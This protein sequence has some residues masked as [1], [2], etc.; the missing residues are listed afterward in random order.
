MKAFL[1]YE[2]HCETGL[3]PK[4]ALHGCYGIVLRGQADFQFFF[5]LHIHYTQP[6][7][8][9]ERSAYP[10]TKHNGNFLIEATRVT[11]QSY[12]SRKK[13]SCFREPGT[14]EEIAVL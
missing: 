11:H 2:R 14:V 5:C 1:V 4:V 12:S 7:V 10:C 6:P 8:F 9:I 13:R 3:L